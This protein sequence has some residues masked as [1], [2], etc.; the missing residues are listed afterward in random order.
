MLR[1]VTVAALFG[2]AD[3]V[4]KPNP[5][6]RVV[7]LLEE[8]AEEIEAEVAKEKTAY[9]KFQ[10]YC[11]KNDGELGKKA[12]EQAALI[13]RTKAEVESLTGQKK[14]LAA[15]LKKHK[16]ERAQAQKDLSSATKKRTE[17]KAKYD[18]ATKDVK[19]TL[20]DIDKAITALQ[21]GMG[22]SFLQT[23]AAAE[24]KQL[25]NSASDV[26]LSLLDKMDVSD[27]RVVSAFL[28]QKKDYAP[29]GGE[30]VGILKMMKDNF[31]ESLGGIIGEEEAA[32]AAYKK[33]KVSLEALIKSSGAAIE[34]K[35]ELKGGVAVKIVEGK[36]LISTTE[37]QMG[38]D[39]AT[40]AELKEAC[41][42]KD[43]EFETRQKDAA[44]EVDAIHQA[45]A[46][47]DSDDS[48]QLFNKTDT[49]AE[50]GSFLQVATGKNSP[51]AKT[52]QELS[53]HF[54]NK[55]VSL[56]AFSAK[57]MLKSKQT[58]DFSKVIKM[59][60]D[61]VALLKQEAQDDLNSRDKC[62]ADFNDSEAE[63]KEVGHAIEGLNA[64]IEELAAVASQKAEVMQK[65]SEEI[66]ASKTAMAEAT[67]QRKTDNADF[68]VAVD[69]N[70][71]AV[72]LIQKAKNKLNGFY[73]PQ[74]VPKEKAPELSP[75]EEIE[76]GARTVFAQALPKG[77]PETWAA[78]DRKNKGQKG[79]SVIALMDML[80]NDLN[81]DTQALE[82]DEATAQK[83]YEK[84][85]TDL[86]ASVAES[87]SILNDAKS[88]KANAEESKQTA[89]STLSMKEEEHQDVVQTIKD[90]HAQCDFI[91]AAFEERKAARENEVAGLGKAKAILSGAKFD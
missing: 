2:A 50:E 77:A 65:S 91:I 46:I 57:S 1:L 26:S 59:V 90:L 3:A 11:K 63:K 5:I 31:D 53:R 51:I 19:K 35:T 41:G 14:Q 49:K 9:A 72:T 76:A 86:A 27:Q 80:A 82:H 79:S 47:L 48:L 44:A 73:N 66:A 29:A 28:E 10:C 55:A 84:L 39:A 45:V 20:D 8:M 13:K 60:D 67:A 88:S 83:D 54:D 71:Q 33:L 87:Q 70:K 75:E 52:L 74:L 30:I 15:E 40:L 34:K 81:K 78:G 61:M 58:V 56:L 89:E 68:I 21:K 6:R 17:E 24:L 7:T 18:E 25:F 42:G 37:K 85:S 36:N 32:V 22:K 64:S 43:G 4:T 69:L 38:D 12:A 62:T 16:A 23:S